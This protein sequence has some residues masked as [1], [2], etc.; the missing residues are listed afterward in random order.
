MKVI[1]VIVDE[2]PKDCKH[3]D[4]KLH[5]SQRCGLANRTIDIGW[6]LDKTRPDW[7]PLMREGEVFNW[8]MHRDVTDYE[9]NGMRESEDE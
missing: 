6:I 2:M 9:A 1:K 3:C 5:V 7:C 4:Y 8:I